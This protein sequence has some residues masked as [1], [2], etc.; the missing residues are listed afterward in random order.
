LGL[1]EAIIADA[2]SMIATEELVADD[3]LDEI[4]RT[5]EDIR[6]KNEEIS[7]LRAELQAQHD[8]L[9]ARL[10]KIEDER[11]NILAA[12]RRNA[13][14]ELEEFRKDLKRM[15]ADMRDA[16]VSLEPIMTLQKAAN[17]LEDSLKQPVQNT[18]EMPKETAWAPRLGDTVW[19]ATLNTEGVI[20]E[21]AQSEAMVQVGNLRVRAG[22]HELK[23]RSESQKRQIKR[24]QARTYERSSDPIVPRG[25]SPGLELDLR[26]QRVED[27]VSRLDS[28]I[29]AAYTAGLPFVRI[30]HGKGTGALRKAV[31]ETLEGHSLIARVSSGEA[32]EGGDGVTVVHLVPQV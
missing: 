4:H 28:F 1:D 9:Q 26:G 19:L 2:R 11:R 5:R 20:T 14:G 18:V 23:P 32:K 8:E 3:L 17:N 10:D 24:G 29:D 13:E 30:I 27:A 16:G 25:K 7:E 6:R 21:L 31:R 12:A 15:R 22:L